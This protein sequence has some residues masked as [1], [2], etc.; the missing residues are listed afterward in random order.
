MARV[1]SRPE[2]SVS[3]TVCFSAAHQLSN[4]AWTME[5]NARVYGKCSRV[6]G[7]GHNYTMTL[8]VAGTYDQVTG[9]VVNVTVLHDLL[10]REVVDQLDHRNLN[11]DVPFLAGVVPTMENLAVK[12]ADRL[13]PFLA[14]LG[15]TMRSIELAESE[16]NRVILEY[17]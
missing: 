9:M 17:P 15:V 5:E 2:M 6:G 4:P 3:R 7:H 10:K 12:I 11:E 8:R 16:T 1:R 13:A 14:S